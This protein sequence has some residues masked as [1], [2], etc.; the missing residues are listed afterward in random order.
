MKDETKPENGE[1][2]DEEFVPVDDSNLSVDE[3]ID[4][5]LETD[6]VEIKM[7]LEPRLKL[8]I[9]LIISS[10]IIS[11]GVGPIGALWYG[12]MWLVYSYGFS[13][14]VFILGIAVGG[15]AANDAVKNW[16]VRVRRRIGERLR[17]RRDRDAS[18]AS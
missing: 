5:A 10:F 11:L 9:A 14:V 17:R 8:G 16:R 18:S 15:R 1:S 2:A 7:R 3:M 6:Q 13:W 12:S 4:A